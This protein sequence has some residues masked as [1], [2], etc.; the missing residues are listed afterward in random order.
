MLPLVGRA[1]DAWHTFGHASDIERKWSI[2]ERSAREAGRDPSSIARS[3]NLSISEP[4]DE[5]ESRAKELVEI[6]LDY[7]I[8]S[9]PADGRERVEEFLE[10]V[11]PV[12][13][14]S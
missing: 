8:V 3:T 2:V 10:K 12:L 6:G 14:A 5:V 13:T 4:W 1:A 7:V 11:G 9:W